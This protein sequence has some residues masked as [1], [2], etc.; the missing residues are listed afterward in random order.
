MWSAIFYG[1][2]LSLR[3]YQIE[4][5]MKYFNKLRI[6]NEIKMFYCCTKTYDTQN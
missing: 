1:I 5:N 2:L 4:V 6:F 3:K